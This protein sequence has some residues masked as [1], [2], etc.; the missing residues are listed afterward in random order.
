M[1]FLRFLYWD[2][3][4]Y[5]LCNILVEF[6]IEDCF[7]QPCQRPIGVHQTTPHEHI[8]VALKVI[9]GRAGL[10]RRDLLVEE[11]GQFL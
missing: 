8:T 6:R 2:T 9:A 4:H 7:L 3:H 11:L 1:S 10:Q 5:P